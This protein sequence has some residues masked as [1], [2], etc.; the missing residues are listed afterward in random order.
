MCSDRN[1]L[2]EDVPLVVFMHAVFTR[3]PI[4]SCYGRLGSVLCLCDAS[5]RHTLVV[6]GET[7]KLQ[8]RVMWIQIMDQT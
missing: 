5:Q 6:D 1:N 3:M 7:I 8:K 4:K 2:L